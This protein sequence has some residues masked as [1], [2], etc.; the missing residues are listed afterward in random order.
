MQENLAWKTPVHS[1]VCVSVVD[2]VDCRVLITLKYKIVA[3]SSTVQQ[4]DNLENKQREKE[5]LKSF[6][7]VLPYYSALDQNC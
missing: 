5:V 1:V 7:T 3:P 2:G 4:H 6:T